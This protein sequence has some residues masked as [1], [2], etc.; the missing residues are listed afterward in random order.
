MAGV[1]RQDSVERRRR[2]AVD[3]A[4]GG[5]GEANDIAAKAAPT[6]G[7]FGGEGWSDG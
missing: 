5:D 3:V 4:L 2:T 7:L 1:S 6:V